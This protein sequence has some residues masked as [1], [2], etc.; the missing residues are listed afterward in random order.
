MRPLCE[1]VEIVRDLKSLGELVQIAVVHLEQILKHQGPEE[2]HVFGA[3][4]GM[5]GE[6]WRSQ[7]KGLQ[8]DLNRFSRLGA[9]ETGFGAVAHIPITDRSSQTS[10][11]C[12]LC[13][14]P[15]LVQAPPS[16]PGCCYGRLEEDEAADRC[17]AG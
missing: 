15:R 2:R 9:R 1:V 11:T 3:Q 6:I 14:S 5:D 7:E 4:S 13:L 16:G 17:G 12:W 8:E 10:E